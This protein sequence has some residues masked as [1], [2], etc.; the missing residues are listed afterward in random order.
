MREVRASAWLT[1]AACVV[2]GMLNEVSA[3]VLNLAAP[4][5]A[6]D[7]GASQATSQLFLLAGKLSLGAL[8]LAGGGA[9]D[10]FGRKRTMVVGIALVALA[11]MLSGTA[12]SAGMLGWARALDGLGN[13]LVSP[14]A[15]ALAVMAFPDDMRARI[16]GLFLGISGLGVAV[17][18]LLAAFLIEW[19]GWRVGFLAPLALAVAVGIAIAVLVE[20]QL[21]E[22]RRPPWD[23]IGMLLCVAGLV[24]LV[25]GFVF[26]GSR[27]W[28]APATLALL[29]IGVVG[30]AAFGW[31]ETSRAAIPLLDPALLRTREVLVAIGA[32]V[33]AAMILNGS[34]LPLVYFLQRIHG[35]GP[36]ASVLRML[37]LVVAAMAMAPA[38][39]ALAEG[40]GRRLVMVSGLL[41]IAAGSA[42][43]VTLR[44]DT[45]YGIIALSLAL[46]GA[47]VMTVV[48]PA[49][50]LV[51]S[52]SGP[53]RSGSAAAL[54]GAIMQVGGA[55]GIGVITSV[56]LSQALGGFVARLTALGYT[57]EQL[58]GPIGQL[59]EI[60]RE[61]A[62]NRIPP[63]PEIDPQMQRDILDAYAQ[64]FA[65][66][67][68]RSFLV[69]MGLALVTALVVLAGMRGRR[70]TPAPYP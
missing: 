20:P 40:V 47:G 52:T 4:D 69:A 54:N 60:V 68:G 44:P 38:A 6:R 62:W 41:A 14:L 28:T 12:R 61:T 65:A 55:I 29:A 59:R 3:G 32:A 67:V 43:M 58:V 39:G 30:L 33:V 8:M 37:P 24:A 34:V 50:D 18:P 45:G 17:G 5:A 10:R 25:L 64:A 36:V 19:G 51:M 70:A 15:L 16:V 35:H 42:L 27:G 22:P 31:W 49:A 53:E 7:L 56:F 21:S 11:A 66:G 26:T 46:I 2:A 9:G 48:T 63:M 13:A 23:P 1:L 57:R